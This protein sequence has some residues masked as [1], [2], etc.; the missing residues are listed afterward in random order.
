[1]QRPVT[2]NDLLDGRVGLDIECLDR[3]YLNGYV[4]NLQVSGQVVSFLTRHLGYPIASPALFEKIGTR[5]RD[6]VPVMPPLV[7]CLWCGSR[8][9][10]GRS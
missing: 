2:V 10:T 9:V 7:A 4:A 1:M 8:R 3:I 6:D 5:F